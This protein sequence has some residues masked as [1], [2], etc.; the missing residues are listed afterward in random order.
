MTAILV[1][2]PTLLIWLGEDWAALGGHGRW[3]ERLLSSFF[4]AVT[5]RTAGFNVCPSRRSAACGR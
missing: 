1:I 5:P 3:Y 4:T 2:L